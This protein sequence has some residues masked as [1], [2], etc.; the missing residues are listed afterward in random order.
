[1]KG[2]RLEVSVVSQRLNVS[3]ATVYRLVKE[4]KL[5]GGRVGVSGCIRVLESSV[6]E[7]VKMR[8]ENGDF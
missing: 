5:R 1:M 2:K 3:T 4:K 7:F 8:M 6:D